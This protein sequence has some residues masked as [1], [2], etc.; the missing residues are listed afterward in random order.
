MYKI[1]SMY[2]V[3]VNSE[4]AFPLFQV[5]V[6]VIYFQVFTLAVSCYW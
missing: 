1:I 3:N 5:L 4:K 6:D 2:N